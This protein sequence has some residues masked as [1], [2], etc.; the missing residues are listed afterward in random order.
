MTVIMIM[1]AIMIIKV[2]DIRET[3]HFDSFIS[4]LSKDRKFSSVNIY[5]KRKCEKS[6]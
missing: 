5:R 4:S 2:N 1:I 3:W 6:M